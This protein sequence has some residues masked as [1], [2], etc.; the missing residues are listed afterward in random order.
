VIGLLRFVGLLNAAIWFGASFYFAIAVAPTASS[1]EL[2][3]LLTA[4]NY[5]FF[6]GAIAQ[7]FL[8]R[9]L[10]LHLICAIIAFLHLTAEWI[11]LGRYPQR[12]RLGLLSILF[13]VGLLS[14]YWIQPSLRQWHLLK[15]GR[16][17]SAADREQAA[18]SFRIWHTV[19]ESINLFLLA[20]VGVYFWGVSN[21]PDPAR[22]VS[23]AKFRS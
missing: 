16:T 9:F 18:R 11:Y 4:N 2:Q 22:F 5:P 8:T 7:I 1:Q 19:S 10:R 17:T 13:F 23:T 15:Y 6:G 3:T 21:P 14:A 12:L 20:G